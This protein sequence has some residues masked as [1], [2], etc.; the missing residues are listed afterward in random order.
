MENTRLAAAF[1]Q[2]GLEGALDPIEDLEDSSYVTKLTGGEER[3][4]KL[5]LLDS[6]KD[7]SNTYISFISKDI[8]Y[9]QYLKLFSPEYKADLKKLKDIRKA[10]SQ[11]NNEITA[12]T[13]SILW[14]GDTQVD[15]KAF[16]ERI[17]AV[18][19]GNDLHVTVKYGQ[20]AVQKEEEKI[21]F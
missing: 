1:R 2:V 9:L 10:L 5:L 16:T 21:E 19:K 20:V 18:Q 3:S 17:E 4:N 7:A 15:V 6:A 8:S 13:Q 12:A 14:K 11:I